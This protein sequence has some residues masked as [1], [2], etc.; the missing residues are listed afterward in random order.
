MRVG[1][2]VKLTLLETSTGIPCSIVKAD[3]TTYPDYNK[4]T[5]KKGPPKKVTSY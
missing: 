3:K 5:Q 4:T 2:R 1:I